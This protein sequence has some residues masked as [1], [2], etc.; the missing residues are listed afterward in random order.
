MNGSP[1]KPPSAAKPGARRPLSSRDTAWAAALS[2]ALVR[3]RVSPNAISVL[4]V[5]AA[6][7]SG[8]ALVCA[9]RTESMAT[10][11]ALYLVAAAGIQI[12]L[13]CNLMDGM[14]AVEGGMGGPLGNLYNDLP[15][16]LAD[17]LVLLGVGYG[18]TTVPHAVEL[19]WLAAA[20][21]LL[22]AYVRVLGA[23]AGAGQCFLG[24]M[25]KPHRM[26]TMTVAC[27]LAAGER[28]LALPPRGLAAA[29]GLVV[30][31][32]AVTIARRLYRIAA[33]LKAA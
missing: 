19:G 13:L 32:C 1:A 5:V 9:A 18:T 24:P 2:R 21:A 11:V 33:V 6:G 22:T 16:R 20:L 8:V 17:V 23:E 27:L 25:A 28:A 30:L 10:A 12:R 26:A 7:G 3:W 29:L 14:V 15:D 31:G 4:S